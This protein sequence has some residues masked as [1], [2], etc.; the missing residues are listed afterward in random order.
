MVG[1]TIS[2]EQYEY[3]TTNNLTPEKLK[4][5]RV[6]GLQPSG[7]G[8]F[9]FRLQD[10]RDVDETFDRILSVG[11]FEHVGTQ[12]YGE[13]FSVARRCLKE[14]GI[15]LLHTIGIGYTHCPQVEPWFNK[16]VLFSLVH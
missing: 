13:F 5:L 11:M 12:N 15:F 4:Y 10:Y 6:S 2:K 1:I 14:D 16:W 8:S 3:E 7:D 9:E